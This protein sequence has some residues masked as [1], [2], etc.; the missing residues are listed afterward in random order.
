[1]KIN[2]KHQATAH[3]KPETPQLCGL[4]QACFAK[5][6]LTT[7]RHGEHFQI[8]RLWFFPAVIAFLRLQEIRRNL[9]MGRNHRLS[10]MAGMS[11]QEAGKGFTIATTA[12]LGR[13]AVL[14]LQARLGSLLR[15]TRVVDVRTL[16]TTGNSLLGLPHSRS[17]LR[18]LHGGRPPIN[19]L[20]RRANV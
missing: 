7:Q 9:W 3:A 10:S 1:M 14:L 19:M 6:A 16:I 13:F 17:V 8:G 15:N 4:D 11:A 12:A 5:G 18:K 2:N 20:L